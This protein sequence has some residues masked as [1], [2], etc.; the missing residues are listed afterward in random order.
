MVPVPSLPAPLAAALEALPV[1]P[2][3]LRG[4]H[5]RLVNRQNRGTICHSLGCHYGP[6]YKQFFV[7]PSAP[8]AV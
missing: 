1:T 7:D 3:S 4:H 5:F 2:V 8:A 6:F